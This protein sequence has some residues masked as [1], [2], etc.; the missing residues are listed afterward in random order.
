MA[1]VFWAFPILSFLGHSA[2]T[3]LCCVPGGILGWLPVRLCWP[4]KQ[5]WCHA[6]GSLRW[7]RS[8]WRTH[9]TGA[10]QG[11]AWVISHS[12]R[13]SWC[14]STGAGPYLRL[15]WLHG[16]EFT[17][18]R[19]SDVTWCGLGAHVCSEVHLTL[20]NIPGGVWAAFWNQTHY[21]C[22]TEKEDCLFK[23]G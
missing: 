3:T 2:Q 19:I 11:P 7:L 20:G 22:F 13:S 8:F 10:H 17:R 14:R 18:F 9:V 4:E 16:L 23:M 15:M 12:T 1:E 21:Y 6:Q 5:V